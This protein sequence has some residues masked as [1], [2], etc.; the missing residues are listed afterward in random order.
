MPGR[1]VAS[2]D[3]RVPRGHDRGHE[4]FDEPARVN[5]LARTLA[6]VD[7][8]RHG[9]GCANASFAIVPASHL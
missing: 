1:S 8:R 6:Q 2:A 9:Y 4:H 5:V 3:A 7:G